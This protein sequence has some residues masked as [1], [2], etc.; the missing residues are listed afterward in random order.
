MS[1]HVEACPGGTPIGAL[2]RP[3]SDEGWIVEQEADGDVE[4]DRIAWMIMDHPRDWRMR[5]LR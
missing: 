4:D 3:P 2:D 1:R 5:R